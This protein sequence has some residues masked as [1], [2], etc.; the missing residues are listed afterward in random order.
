M[1]MR[2]FG[3]VT[4]GLEQALDLYEARHRVLTENV[5]NADTPGY[6]ARDLDFGNALD[7]AFESGTAPS[8]DKLQPTVDRSATVK[9]DN[10]SVDLDTQMGKLSENAFKIVALS[11]ILARRYDALKRTIDGGK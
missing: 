10:N 7:A 11:Q 3:A 8:P 6:R 2:M 4:E 9:I 1:A 5:A